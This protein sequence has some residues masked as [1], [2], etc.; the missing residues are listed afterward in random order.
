MASDLLFMGAIN[1]ALLITVSGVIDYKLHAPKK[2][3][4]RELVD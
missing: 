3:K 1:L 4:H 2:K